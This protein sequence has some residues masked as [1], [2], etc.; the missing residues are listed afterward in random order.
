LTDTHPGGI[1]IEASGPRIF[2]TLAGVPK[3]GVVDREKR[4]QTTAWPLTGVP[5]VTALAL[6]ETHHRLFGG[7]RNPPMLIVLDT[8]SGKDDSNL[9]IGARVDSSQASRAGIGNA[10]SDIKIFG[11]RVVA[12]VIW[13]CTENNPKLKL[14]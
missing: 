3:V 12:H 14:P 4:Q 10:D 13:I 9:F 5:G 7:S 2:V 8:E 6:D 11:C 1:K